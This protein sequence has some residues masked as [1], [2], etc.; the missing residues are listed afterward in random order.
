MR[1]HKSQKHRTTPLVR[2]RRKWLRENRFPLNTRDRSIA[3]SGV[4][5]PWLQSGGKTAEVEEIEAWIWKVVRRADRIV[6]KKMDSGY[7]GTT[8]RYDWRSWRR[9][10]HGGRYSKRFQRIYAG[11]SRTRGGISLCLT[12][13]LIGQ[14]CWREYAHIAHSPTIGDLDNLRPGDALTCLCCHE[15]AHAVDGGRD[16]HGAN[17]QEIYRTLRIAF[18]LVA[19][20]YN[21]ALREPIWQNSGGRRLSDPESLRAVGYDLKKYRSEKRRVQQKARRESE[22][23]KKKRE[24]KCLCCG[25]ALVGRTSRAKFCS[26]TC[27]SADRRM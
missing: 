26:A 6:R 8:V 19:T 18:G 4:L 10:S 20:G 24:E 1:P 5:C 15:V 14:R 17:W 9:R 11:H 2:E 22:R 27:R 3:R 25:I 13:G 12:P 23:A 7:A 21:A 16:G